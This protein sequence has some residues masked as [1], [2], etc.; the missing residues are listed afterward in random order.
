[1]NYVVSMTEDEVA[2]LHALFYDVVGGPTRGPRRHVESLAA[3]LPMCDPEQRNEKYRAFIRNWL[4]LPG[5]TIQQ[6]V[7]IEER[8]QATKE[9]SQ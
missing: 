5:R 6:Y 4:L 2:V 8:P 3:K 9:T 1:M 7:V